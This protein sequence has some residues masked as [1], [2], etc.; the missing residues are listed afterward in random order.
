[1]ALE[2]VWT[3]RAQVGFSEIVDYL[4]THFAEKEIGEFIRQTRDFLELLSHYPE[5]LE[6][7]TK[8]KHLRRG[9]INKYTIL[10]Y[11]VKPRKK[12]IE[13]IN[14]RSSRQRLPK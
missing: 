13:L 5:I 4:D 1:M 11:R 12:Q 8:Q 7:S 10:T 14:I 6:S 9:P 2:I 3:K